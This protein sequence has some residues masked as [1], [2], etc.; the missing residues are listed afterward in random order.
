[1]EKGFYVSSRGKALLGINH[2]K[3]YK[4]L[5]PKDQGS[6]DKGM[7]IVTLPLPSSYKSVIHIVT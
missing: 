7:S 6:Q 5:T 3:P 2:A 4:G 1:M